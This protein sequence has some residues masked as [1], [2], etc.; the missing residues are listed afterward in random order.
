MKNHWLD[1]NKKK[2]A[3]EAFG[4]FVVGCNPSVITGDV[5]VITIHHNIPEQI[6]INMSG[7]TIPSPQAEWT[8]TI[9]S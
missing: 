6:N 5:S 3:E 1:K 9:T 8:Y 2:E 7:I 4:Q